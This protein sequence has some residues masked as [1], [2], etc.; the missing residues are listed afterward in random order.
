MK[1]TNFQISVL[2]I[3][4]TLLFSFFWMGLRPADI[5]QDCAISV[6]EDVKS[7]FAGFNEI[8]MLEQHYD[9]LYETCL[10]ANGMAAE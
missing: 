8:S 10:N 2:A 7:E 3:F 5:R 4:I 6:I 9:K 1:L